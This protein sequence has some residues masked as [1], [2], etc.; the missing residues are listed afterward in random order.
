VHPPLKFYRY[1]ESEEERLDPSQVEIIKDMEKS[2]SKTCKSVGSSLEAYYQRISKA[3]NDI[4]KS[5]FSKG[6]C[7][8]KPGLSKRF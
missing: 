2:V 7:S 6:Y 4:L 5:R 8:L 1:V 3:Y